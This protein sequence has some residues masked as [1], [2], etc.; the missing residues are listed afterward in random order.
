MKVFRVNCFLPY[1]GIHDNTIKLFFKKVDAEAYRDKL[2]ED[3]YWGP[4]SVEIVEM[5]VE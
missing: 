1:E 4:A 3:P 2:L 5:D